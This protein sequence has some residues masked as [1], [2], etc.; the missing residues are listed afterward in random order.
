MI[1]TLAGMSR[2]MI[3]VLSTFPIL[4]M[5]SGMDICIATVEYLVILKAICGKDRFICLMLW[6]CWKLLQGDCT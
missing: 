5:A 4:S 6:Y 2:F 3:G 1:D